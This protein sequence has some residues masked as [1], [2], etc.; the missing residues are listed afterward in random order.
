M[1]LFK[2]KEPSLFIEVSTACM[3]TSGGT[4]VKVYPVVM[5]VVKSSI[6]TADMPSWVMGLQKKVEK[7]KQYV[8]KV[9]YCRPEI[10]C[11]FRVEA[12]IRG[13]YSLHAATRVTKCI[14]CD[15][16][17]YGI[18]ITVNISPVEYIT[19][20][21]NVIRRAEGHFAVSHVATPTAA[22]KHHFS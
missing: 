16:G 18:H 9:R 8:R 13:N 1:V 22:Q 20:L 5:H 2:D 17:N 14:F 6:K 11:G 3:N 4:T 19:H 15:Y 7:V 10:L 21:E 12:V